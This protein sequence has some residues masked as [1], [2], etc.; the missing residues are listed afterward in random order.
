MEKVSVNPTV[1]TLPERIAEDQADLGSREKASAPLRLYLP[2]AHRSLCGCFRL[3][4]SG[5][6][7]QILF[8]LNLIVPDA[9]RSGSAEFTNKKK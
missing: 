7:N 9:M 3:G 1:S 4:Q 5:R 2:S 8:P 6:D